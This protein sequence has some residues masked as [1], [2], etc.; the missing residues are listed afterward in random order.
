MARCQALLPH[1]VLQQS[2]GPQFIGVAEILG[3]VAGAV[4]HPG[5]G[6]I[7]DAATFAWPRQFSQ[8]GTIPN[9][10]NLRTH[11]AT[12]WRFTPFAIATAWSLIP[13]AHAKR[14]AA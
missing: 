8:C 10:R 4:R 14:M 1:V 5:N 6:I 12:V 3:L 9:C 13:L 7:R 2:V 11:N